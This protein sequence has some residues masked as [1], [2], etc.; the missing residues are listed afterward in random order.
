MH[1]SLIVAAGLIPA[2]FPPIA[3]GEP[4]AADGLPLVPDRHLEL[5]LD[6]GTWLSFD[7]RADGRVLVFDLL[8]DLYT[9]PIEGGEA[10]PVTQGPAFDSQP[11]YSPDGRRIA[12]IS[13]R[14]GAENLW[15]SDAD[16]ENARRLSDD[17]DKTV[18][19]SPAWSADGG[20][21]FVSRRTEA[22]GVF[23]LWLHYLEGGEGVR[24]TQGGSARRRDE[25]MN[26]LG[27]VGSNDGRYVYYAQKPDEPWDAATNPKW[28]IVRRDLESGVT[29]PVL[30]RP[31]SAMRP[32]LS[33]D[34]R[35]LAYAARHDGRTGLRLRDLQTGGDRWLAFPVERDEQDGSYSRDT[36]PRYDFTPDG[37]SLVASIGGQPHR[38]D[39]A[40][41]KA[42]RLPFRVTATI[43]IGPY[44][45]RQQG[46]ETG[47]VRAR[48]IQA[49]RLSP[50]GSRVA[51][52]ALTRLYVMDLPTNKVRHVETGGMPAYQ[53]AWSSD[54]RWLAF[55]TWDAVDGGHVFRV[56]SDARQLQRV[57]DAAAHYSDPVWS[58]DGKSLFA[59][60]SSRYDRLRRVEEVSPV[61]L[62]DL[63][64]FSLGSERMDIVAALEVGAQRPYFTDDPERV[65]FTSPQGVASIAVDGSDRRVHF[66]IEGAYPWHHRH[67][68]PVSVEQAVLSPDRRWALTRSGDQ[69]HLLRVPPG[70][71][72]TAVDLTAAPLTP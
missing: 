57:S 31:D 49:P 33:P 67:E 51:F 63:V 30:S 62:S 42:E 53:P 17:T 14:S 3:A 71:D 56:R 20:A 6:E 37:K 5:A 28:N 21:V 46:V 47:P 27:A 32:Q 64:R 55:V 61:R 9:L 35:Y 2:A 13:D 1:R 29:T 65:Y 15:V 23:E 4:A 54:G 18:Y 8:G 25:R 19:A 26:A 43:G 41:G 38:I 7:V 44:L 69:L 59:L 11:A 58:A 40:T 66:R 12:F 36:L 70:G 45:P 39:V 16:G 48:I 68:R 72:D 22:M 52:S 34:G 24:I 60:R 10:T 50:D